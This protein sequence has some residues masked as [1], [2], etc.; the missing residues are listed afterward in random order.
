[1]TVAVYV[2]KESDAA[3]LIPWGVRFARADHSDLLIISTKRSKGKVGWEDLAI[4]KCSE[5]ALHAA[6]FK[7]IEGLNQEN[8]VLK[9]DIAA[10]VESSDMDR[11]AIETKEFS[12]PSPDIAIINELNKLGLSLLLVP[13]DEPSRAGKHAESSSMQLFD[14]SPCDTCLIRGVAPDESEPIR[15]LLATHGHTD[16]DIELKR[17]RQLAQTYNG[18]VTVLYVRP[19]DDEVADYV[20]LRNLDRMVRSVPGPY[21][22]FEKQI[23]LAD[24]LLDGIN[25][26]DLS[27]FDL[28][29]VGSRRLKS[30]RRVFRGLEDKPDEPFVTAV[31]T[32]REGIPLAS[33]LWTK[34]QTAFRS[35]IPQLNREQRVE[36]VDRLETNS[37]FDFD[38]VALIS[39]STLIAGLGLI[40]NSGAVVIGAMLIAPLMTPL[41]GI[42]FALIQ[43]NEKLIRNAMRSVGFG[44]AVA[45][46]ISL[47]LGFVNPGIETGDQLNSEMRGR[48]NPN[49][50]DLVVALVSGIAGAYATGRPNLVS[51]LPGVAIAAAL[52]PP[53]ATSGIVLATGEL[54]LAW[55]AFL[56]F[57]TNI[58]AIVLGTTF[59]FWAIG[60]NSVTVKGEGGRLPR[61]WPR[62]YFLAFVIL[63]FLLAAF[64]T[65]HEEE[66]VDTDIDTMKSDIIE[67]KETLDE[68]DDEIE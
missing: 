55:G 56:L 66:N 47:F 63:S 40:R 4:T 7:A 41:V 50:L 36:L 46:A 49:L 37:T 62:Y 34:F 13:A 25:R 58:V 11:V 9:Q 51:A 24:T 60:I 23:E 12:A 54:Q 64:F 59:A 29:I 10:G 19:D 48:C 1:M 61:V 5:R 15:I 45:F 18:S 27:E 21:D 31:S 42:G 43:G 14:L 65:L 17:S 57:F 33:R 22:A 38:F 39:L 20:A 32:M 52:V 6:I 44:F 68:L 16:I 2:T 35:K 8:V 26:K 30:L 53:I 67:L 28:V 3:N